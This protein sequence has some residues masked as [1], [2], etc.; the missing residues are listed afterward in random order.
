MICSLLKETPRK[1]SR[2]SGGSGSHTLYKAFLQGM[3]EKHTIAGER[4]LPMNLPALW[5]RRARD[6]GFD[7]HPCWGGLSSDD[8]TIFA[9]SMLL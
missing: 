3:Y 9:S 6:A 4:R 7:S 1:L 2:G 5:I 8:A